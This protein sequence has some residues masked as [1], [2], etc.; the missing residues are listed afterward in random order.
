[1]TLGRKGQLPAGHT[2]LPCRWLRLLTRGHLHDPDPEQKRLQ[3]SAPA[4]RPAEFGFTTRRNGQLRAEAPFQPRASD[5]VQ[6]VQE[7]TNSTVENR[8]HLPAG[9][10]RGYF[11]GP[12][13][14]MQGFS[15]GGGNTPTN[16]V[17]R[18]YDFNVH[19]SLISPCS[20]HRY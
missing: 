5:I 2:W 15:N 12:W 8:H 14:S 18:Y 6:I 19:C 20:S 17:A 3:C 1:M 10:G 16:M 13:S 7:Q 11:T 9:W 4:Y